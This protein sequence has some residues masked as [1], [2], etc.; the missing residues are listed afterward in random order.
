MNNHRLIMEGWRDFFRAQ[1]RGGSN[2]SNLTPNRNYDKFT[3]KY[4]YFYYKVPYFTGSDRYKKLKT[5]SLDELAQII[6]KHRLGEEFLVRPNMM[7]STGEF[8]SWKKFKYLNS[9]VEEIKKQKE[10]AERKER[11][12]RR[13]AIEKQ[14]GKPSADSKLALASI[15][16]D[17]SMTLV[18]YHT[19][20]IDSDGLPMV[21]GMIS[22]ATMFGPCIP[23]TLQVKFAAVAGKFQRQGFG[24]ILYRLAAAYAKLNF[25]DGGI[26]S[27]HTS[28]TSIDAEKRWLAIRS[29]PEFYK[30]TTPSGSDEFDY[31]GNR[32]PDDRQDDCEDFT[33]RGAVT[34]HSF[35]VND[36][37]VEVYKDLTLADEYFQTNGRSYRAS[38]LHDKAFRVFGKS[39]ANR[40]RT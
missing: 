21:I 7:S 28:G 10:E 17:D 30:R 25:R 32:T 39:Y 23:N 15:S 14:R 8:Y 1:T 16:M 6:D 3:Q 20:V 33:D 12:A 38:E 37:S 40:T 2:P 22:I 19:E 18:L 24:S 13:A 35:G 9:K 31:T 5:T 26:S 4:D 29:D 34:S 11:E 27:D 36:K